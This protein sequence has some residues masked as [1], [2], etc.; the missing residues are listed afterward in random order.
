MQNGSEPREVGD[1]EFMGLARD[2]AKARMLRKIMQNLSKGDADDP[3]TELA[4]DV[5]SG[6]RGIREALDTMPR[7]E[8][9]DTRFDAF[10][11]RWDAMSESDRLAAE[12]ESTAYLAEQHREIR[13]ER[14]AAG[15]TGTTPPRHRARG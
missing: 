1:V 8:S 12:R 5:M 3:L 9:L 4:R 2:E 7:D 6:R 15:H 14:E 11:Q 13:A 10:Q